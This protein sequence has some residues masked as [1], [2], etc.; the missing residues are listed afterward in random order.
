MENKREKLTNTRLIDEVC[1]INE[2]LDKALTLLQ[3]ITEGY[4]WQ[5]DNETEDGRL[6]ICWEFPR[7][8]TYAE[9]VNDYVL[10]AKDQLQNLKEGALQRKEEEKPN[11][12][13][14]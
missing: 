7:T 4:F 9:I 2:K 5:Y 10:Q 14:E 8:A 12:T 3:D 13:S 1:L 11:L 6:S